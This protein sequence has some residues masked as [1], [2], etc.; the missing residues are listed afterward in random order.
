V[1]TPSL[2]AGTLCVLGES[3]ALRRRVRVAESSHDACFLVSPMTRKREM[4]WHPPPGW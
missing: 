1:L 4:A 3:G 2:D